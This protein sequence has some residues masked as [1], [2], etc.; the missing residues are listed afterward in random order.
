MNLRSRGR[1]SRSGGQTLVEFAIVIPLILLMVLG[2]V[3][4]GRGVYAYNTLAQAARQGN[5]LAIVDQ[6]VDRVRTQAIAYAPTLGLGTGSVDVCFKT[7]SSSQRDCSSPATDNCPAADRVIGCLAVVT[8]HMSYQPITP[9]I[10]VFWSS[11]SL[12]ST[13]IEP[14]EYVCPTGTK[15]TCP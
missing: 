14:I 13:S 4:L 2:L 1:G 3:D 5:R 15:T 9:V 6:D 7:E 11:I 12:S 10:S 8:A